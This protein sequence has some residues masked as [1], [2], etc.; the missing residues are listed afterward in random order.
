MI[1]ALPVLLLSSPL[2]WPECLPRSTAEI[3]ERTEGWER[4]AVEALAGPGSDW[5]AGGDCG[6][7]H[8]DGCDLLDDPEPWHQLAVLY[9]DRSAALQLRRWRGIVG[10]AV[11]LAPLPAAT[12][13][14]LANGLGSAGLL[15]LGGECGWDLVCMEAVYATTRHRQARWDAAMEAGR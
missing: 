13:A 4:A 10:P 3:L 2:V 8:L 1:A 15:R 14:V 9:S 7:W 6:L 11:E 12:S 5:T